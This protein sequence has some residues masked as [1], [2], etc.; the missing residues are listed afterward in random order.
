M[1][2]PYRDKMLTLLNVTPWYDLLDEE[3]TEF[4]IA[5]TFR[6]G[7]RRYAF[8]L[9]GWPNVSLFKLSSWHHGSLI[10]VAEGTSDLRYEFRELVRKENLKGLLFKE[11]WDSEQGLQGP[12]AWRAPWLPA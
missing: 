11:I 7:I 4:I 1:P 2:L 6:I 3:H 10:M 5:N 8:R 9:G 12:D